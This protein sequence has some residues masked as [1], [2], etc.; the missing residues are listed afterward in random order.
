MTSLHFLSVIVGTAPCYDPLSFS[1]CPC[2]GKEVW[3]LTPLMLG[4]YFPSQGS[5]DL[6]WLN[7]TMEWYSPHLQ[8]YF[9]VR[10]VL[11]STLVLINFKFNTLDREIHI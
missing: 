8:T 6:Y 3:F 9:F 7:T 10:G 2:S 1:P 4:Y 5:T 11:K